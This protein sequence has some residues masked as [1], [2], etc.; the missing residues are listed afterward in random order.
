MDGTAQ[1]CYF[2]YV[3]RH[4]PKCCTYISFREATSVYF[5]DKHPKINKALYSLAY[6]NTHLTRLLISIISLPGNVSR[7]W[8]LTVTNCTDNV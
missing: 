8:P 3:L 1:G 2:R 7:S 5:Q 4:E 6:S